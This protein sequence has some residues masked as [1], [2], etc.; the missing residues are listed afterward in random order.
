VSVGVYLGAP[1]VYRAPPLAPDVALAPIRLDVTGFVGVAWR[2]PVN[3]PTLITSW[4][5]FVDRFGG[6]TDP[7]GRPCPG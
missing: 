3:E 2:G 1:G 5:Q 6:L 4:S 7:D